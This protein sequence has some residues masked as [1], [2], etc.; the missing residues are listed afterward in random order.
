MIFFKIVKEMLVQV[1][2]SVFLLGICVFVHELGHFLIGKWVG[3]RPKIFSIGYGRG[4]FFKKVKGTIYQITAIPLGGYVQFYG[5]DITRSHEKIRKGDFFSVGPWRRIALAFGG[6]LFSIL[7]GFLVIGSL[8]TSG[9]Q[10]IT[11]KV[12]VMSDETP[13]ARSGIQDGD[14]IVR[15]NGVETESFEKIV[16]HVSLSSKSALDVQVERKGQLLDMHVDAVSSEPGMPMQIGIRPEGERFLLVQESRHFEHSML[17]PDDK[18]IAVNGNTVEAIDDLRQIL[19]RNMGSQVEITIKRQRNGW[20]A[21]SEERVFSEAVPVKKVEYFQLKDIRDVQT[22]KNI[23]LIEIGAWADQYKKIRIDGKTYTEWS[24][25]Q[26]ALIAASNN[27]ANRVKAQ[28]GTVDVSFLLKQETRGMLGISLIEAVE[29]A[30]ASLPTDFMSRLAQTYDYTIFATKSTLLGLYRIIEGKLSFRKSISGPV[31]IMAIAAQTVSS[32]WEHYWFLL[33]NIT[34]ILGVMNLLPIP[35]LDGGHIMFY[36]IE[37]L[38]RPLPVTAI[39]V[40]MRIGMILLI[41]MGLYVI[42]LDIWDVFLRR[43]VGG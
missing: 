18:V 4:L 33:A 40:S 42:G 35:V 9:W 13:A 5:D 12:Q 8:I 37:A 14:R 31:K 2:A 22:G 19:D 17:L 24:K 16:Y 29:P 30:K 27:G 11:N 28:I 43:L 15:V 20:F 23:E 1:L 36:L 3:V 41:A 21:P 6:P 10:P 39:S 38:Y 34:I 25:F 32:G 26:N 7:F